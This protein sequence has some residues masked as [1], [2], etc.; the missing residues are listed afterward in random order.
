MI[1][2]YGC[3]L[4]ESKVKYQNRMIKEGDVY[5]V[6]QDGNHAKM[7]HFKI[8]MIRDGIE[9]YQRAEGRVKEHNRDKE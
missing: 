9:L 6:S 3:E 2:K 4:K 1:T 7:E 8:K 5:W